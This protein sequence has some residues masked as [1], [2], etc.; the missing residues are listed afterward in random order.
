MLKK[1]VASKFNKKVEVG[2]FLGYNTPLK[3]VYNKS[4]GNIEEWFEVDD[5]EYPVEPPRKGHTWMFSSQGHLDSFNLPP[6]HTEEEL[7]FQ[8]MYD[9]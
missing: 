4:T 7:V 6:D 2:I 3:W 9:T 5:Q 1:S 8:M